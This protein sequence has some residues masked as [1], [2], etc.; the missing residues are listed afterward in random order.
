M[1]NWVYLNEKKQMFFVKQ[2]IF[3]LQKQ[4]P[5][6]SNVSQPLQKQSL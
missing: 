5:V 4:Y 2:K 1:E 6:L 3:T